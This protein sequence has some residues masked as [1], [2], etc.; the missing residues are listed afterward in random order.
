MTKEKRG[1]ILC[2]NTTH[3]RLVFVKGNMGMRGESVCGVV[4]WA[5]A[6]QGLFHRSVLHHHV[7]M[8]SSIS[9]FESG[10]LAIFFRDR[11]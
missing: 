2:E 4:Q 8:V 10:E 1:G 9:S 5:S 7:R 11:R 6:G 3:L